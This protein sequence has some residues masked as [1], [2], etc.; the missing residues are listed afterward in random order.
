[1]HRIKETVN[2]MALRIFGKS[3]EVVQKMLGT[4]L[5]GAQARIGKGIQVGVLLYE[6]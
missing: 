4:V 2:L 5:L 6:V 3:R 1:M